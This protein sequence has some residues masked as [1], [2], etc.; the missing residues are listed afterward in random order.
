VSLSNHRSK[1]V[2]SCIMQ[3]NN[4][5]KQ[6]IIGA[7]PAGLTAGIYSSRAN[8]KPLIITGKNPGGQLMGTTEVENWPGNISIL[9]PTLMMNMQKH[10]AHFGSILLEESVATVDFKKKPFSITTD[11][12]THLTADSIIIATGASPKKLGVPG[13]EEY[14]G[15]GVTTC[16]V[17]DGAFYKDRPVVIVG[18]GDTA[19]ENASFMLNF[20]KQITIVHILD[21]L[22]ASFAMQ[23]QV[24]DNPNIKIIY[25]STVSEIHGDGK[26]VT[27]VTIINRQT[28]KTEKL[29]VDAVFVAIGLNPNVEPFKGHL[30]FNKFGFIDVKDYTKTS[31]PGIFVAGD[32]ADYRYRQA[33]TS[34][35]AGCMAALDAEKYLKTL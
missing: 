3:K 24:I 13:E 20:T 14:W 1:L 15:K 30:A 5:H 2:E 9:G 23:T 11:K 32:V 31:I 19:M 25:N 18:G 8:L 12:G 10:A 6:I 4:H 7:G 29:S 22:T 34:A 17:C 16:A 27:G 33:I 26:H 21:K 35:G 28:N